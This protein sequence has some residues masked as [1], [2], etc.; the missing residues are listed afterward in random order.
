MKDVNGPN[1]HTVNSY[2]KSIKDKRQIQFNT[3][4]TSLFQTKKYLKKIIP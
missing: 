2:Y 3:F 1:K 4:P